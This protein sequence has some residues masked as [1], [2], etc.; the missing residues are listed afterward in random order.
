MATIIGEGS[1]GKILYN[2]LTPSIVQKIH[3]LSSH[4]Q[5]TGCDEIF[6]HEYKFHNLL[7]QKLIANPTQHFII[8]KPINYRRETQTMDACIYSM[9]KLNYPSNRLLKKIIKPEILKNYV[10]TNPDVHAPPYLLFSAISDDYENGKVKLTNIQGVENWNQLFFIAE[11][12][13][14]SFLLAQ[15]MIKQFFT[16]S[17]ES[18]TVLQDVEFLLTEKDKQLS[19]G[20]IDFNQVSDFDTRFRMANKRVQNYSLDYD[21]ANTYLFLSGIDTG[22]ILTDRNTQW[23]FLPTPHILPHL[24]FR[25]IQ[26]M[27]NETINKIVENICSTIYQIEIDSITQSLSS[28][29]SIFDKIMVWHEILIYGAMDTELFEKLNI[30]YTNYDAD[31]TNK[32]ISKYAYF[33]N[34]T[35]LLF[36]YG[37]FEDYYILTSNNNQLYLERMKQK[38]NIGLISK[39]MIEPV[40]HHDI[41]FQRLFII[42]YL[43]KI[44]IDNVNIKKF[45]KLLE[46]NVDFELI[47]NFLNKKRTKQ[48]TKRK[49]RVGLQKTRKVKK[50]SSSN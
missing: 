4:E 33:S 16:L 25:T 2:N 20:L 17:L 26:E 38:Q 23:K 8:P 40:I 49:I 6:Q 42:K 32:L 41:M 48:K 30:T 9:E 1:Y 36:D 21:I 34:A 29:S 39:N 45:E 35:S 28:L 37:N 15:T 31:S 43:L 22:S 47:I 14:F 50:D 7:Y 19:I 10:K 12:E 11:P 3:Y 13:H 5:E 46:K 27:Q 24:F 18:Q 44:G